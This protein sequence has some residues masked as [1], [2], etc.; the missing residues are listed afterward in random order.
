MDQ[1]QVQQLAQ[2]FIDA[3]HAL[4]Q[5]DVGNVDQLAGMYSDDARLVNAALKLAGQERTGQ[6][7]A[8]QFWTEYRRTF[9]EARSD[10]YQV[11][12]NEQ[13]AGLFW[14]TKGTGNDGQPM[15]YDGVSLLV[16]DDQGKIKLF[17]G[18]YDTRELSREVGANLQPGSKR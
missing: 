6:D 11:T 18:Y 14:T 13:A 12:V 10:F 2:Q 15:E 4:E 7:G 17:R 16:F 8:R 5:G 9:G 3:L 1:Q